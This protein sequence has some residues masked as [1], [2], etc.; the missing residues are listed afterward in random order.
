MKCVDTIC[1]NEAVAGF[2]FCKSH[3]EFLNGNLV[4]RNDCKKCGKPKSGIM[5]SCGLGWAI[6]REFG[7][8]VCDAMVFQT[9]KK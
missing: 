3:E 9:W 8:C 7:C 1:P 5:A 4:V 6:E 2:Q